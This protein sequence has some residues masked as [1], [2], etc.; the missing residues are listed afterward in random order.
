MARKATD[1]VI[2]H[3]I[4]FGDL[5]RREFKQS[6]DS[7][8]LVSKANAARAA[9][10]PVVVGGAG[11]GV[12]YLGIKAYAAINDVFSNKGALEVLKETLR[13][14]FDW[15]YDKTGIDL[16]PDALQETVEYDPTV[17][18]DGKY[19]WPPTNEYLF[20]VQW[21]LKATN[22]VNSNGQLPDGVTQQQ[23]IEIMNQARDFVN[24]F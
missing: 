8:Q 1:K 14:P 20:P 16:T 23:A 22:Y 9:L 2:E 13:S 7:Y 21:T 19:F 17:A 5:E 12:A 11:I 4:T 10:I 15:I 6:M 24:Q 3:R 18:G